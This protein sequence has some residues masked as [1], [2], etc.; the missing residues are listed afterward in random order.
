MCLQL[1]GNTV[2]WIIYIYI[3]IYPISLCQEVGPACFDTS[4]KAWFEMGPRRC[5]GFHPTDPNLNPC[6]QC[7]SR[8]DF[9]F[10]TSVV[11]FLHPMLLDFPVPIFPDFQTLLAAQVLDKFS[12]R[13]QPGLLVKK[14]M[15]P[16]IKYI[17]RKLLLQCLHLHQ[18]QA[19][20]T[21][22]ESD[23]MWSTLS[24]CSWM[25]Q[26]NMI[27][28]VFSS[29]IL[30]WKLVRS[31]ECLQRRWK[32]WSQTDI[33]LIHDWHLFVWFYKLCACH[34]ESI[35]QCTAANCMG[36]KIWICTSEG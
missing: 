24:L 23:V 8:M 12:D 18:L 13:S 17:C 1:V 33:H 16:R 36:I 26:H 31:F 25:Q 10:E 35:E 9:G 32:D 19:L 30:S 5:H 29:I 28:T 2:W 4:C 20:S 21:S 11:W 6:W 14:A 3:Y 22:S 7:A 34:P 27:W 15:H